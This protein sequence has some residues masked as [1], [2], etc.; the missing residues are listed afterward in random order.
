MVWDVFIGELIV[1]WFIWVIIDWI[2]G[3]L[4]IFLGYV[5][6]IIIVEKGVIIFECGII[7]ICWWDYVDIV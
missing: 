4:I 2:F 7:S 6:E 3:E 5:F 1:L